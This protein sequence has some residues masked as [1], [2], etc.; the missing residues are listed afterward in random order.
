MAIIITFIYYVFRLFVRYKGGMYGPQLPFSFGC[1][2][3]PRR[4]LQISLYQCANM[5]GGRGCSQ[6]LIPPNHFSL[7]FLPKETRHLVTALSDDHL[8]LFLV[9]EE[10]CGVNGLF[11][12]LSLQCTNEK[13]PAQQEG[14]LKERNCFNLE[15]SL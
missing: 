12:S 1:F 3:L 9:V 10:Y 13:R 15:I 4:H 11:I 7:A 14:L 2:W 5:K 6:M 8:I